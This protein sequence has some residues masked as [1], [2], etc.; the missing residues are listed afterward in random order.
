[1]YLEELI[2]EIFI[3]VLIVNGTKNSWKEFDELK[4]VDQKYHFSDYY[5]VSVNKYGVECGASLRFSEN[6]G[7]VN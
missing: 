7:W 4:N 3:H 5:D 1:M 6:E 2:L